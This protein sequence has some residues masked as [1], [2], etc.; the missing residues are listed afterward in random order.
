LESIGAFLNRKGWEDGEGRV[1]PVVEIE[2]RLR[3]QVLDL[4]ESLGCTPRSRARLGLDLRRQEAFDLA[5]HWQ[6]E[7][8]DGSI[9]GEVEEEG[10]EWAPYSATEMK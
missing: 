2:M 9:E 10:D 6:R 8:E 1:R 4:A 7:S 3:N 5:A